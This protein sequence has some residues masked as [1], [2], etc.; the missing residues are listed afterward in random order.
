MLRTLLSSAVCFAASESGATEAQ[1]AKASRDRVAAN[2][3]KPEVT[4]PRVQYL[5]PEK[6]AADIIVRMESMAEASLR[7]LSSIVVH[8]AVRTYSTVDADRIS[9]PK[10][11]IAE[12]EGFI[13]QY[14]K[15]KR[16]GKAFEH[17]W[18]SRYIATART[19]AGKLLKGGVA[20]GPIGDVLRAKTVDVA[21]E[22]VFQ[23]CLQVTKGVNSFT[24]LT[25]MLAPAKAK[26][27]P[28]AGSK[29]SNAIKPVAGTNASVAKRVLSDKGF[30]VINAIPGK[31]TA[32]AEK[33]AATIAK[34]NVDHRTFVLRALEMI[35]SAEVLIEIADTAK[36]MAQAMIDKA[37][38]PKDK[39]AA[40]KV[41]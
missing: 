36:K 17:A 3:D 20:L 37:K 22:L 10:A 12:I 39:V 31:A 11:L 9:D 38:E 16:G 40:L 29:P 32:K 28:Q 23:H 34:S 4:G 1:L 19:M 25:K 26:A 5:K 15:G 41:G 30:E 35:D 21:N 8:M 18:T 13:Q 27:P 2:K 7:F 24:A 6:T 33:M 14:A